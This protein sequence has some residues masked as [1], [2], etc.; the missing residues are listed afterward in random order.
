MVW[1]V[2]NFLETWTTSINPMTNSETLHSTLDWSI[3]MYIDILY[4]YYCLCM[5]TCN[6]YL[7]SATKW[8]KMHD[9]ARHIPYRC[10]SPVSHFSGPPALASMSTQVRTAS[11]L[12]RRVAAPSPI[13]QVATWPDVTISHHD[14]TKTGRVGK[15][16]KQLKTLNMLWISRS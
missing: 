8:C 9:V 5:H 2:N 15:N 14:I 1:H 11:T 10:V 7:H 3:S 16:L 6:T 13:S 12:A 4:V